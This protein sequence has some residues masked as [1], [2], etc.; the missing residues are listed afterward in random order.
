M[1]VMLDL[2]FEFLISLLVGSG[3]AV[4]CAVVGAGYNAATGV[5]N[6]QVAI[7]V[8][9]GRRRLLLLIGRRLLMLLIRRGWFG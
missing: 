6:Y 3:A 9:I 5:D 8:A 4:G 1:N 2:P 7:D